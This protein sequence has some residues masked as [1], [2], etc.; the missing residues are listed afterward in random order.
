MA[1]DAGELTLTLEFGQGLKDQDWFGKQDPY[2]IIKCGSQTYRSK[3]CTDGGKNPVWNEL[4]R[5]NIINENDVS[6]VCKD[7]DTLGRDDIIGSAT[8][9]LA[10]AREQGSA[11]LQVPMMSK[12]GK[13]H[14]FI[15]VYLVY[16]TNSSMKEATQASSEPLHAMPPYAPAYYSPGAPPAAHVP[17]PSPPHHIFMAPPAAAYYPPP[18]AAAPM[19]HYAGHPLPYYGAILAAPYPLS[20]PAPGA[21]APGRPQKHSSLEVTVGGGGDDE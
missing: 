12:K 10:K 9:T 19:P 5:F 15:S 4:F 1:L 13:Q 2:C 14:G 17:V 7:E 11:R 21:H 3:T 16:S 20:A 6:I 8:F 18:Y